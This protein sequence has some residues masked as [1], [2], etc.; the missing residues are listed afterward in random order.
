VAAW[1]SISASSIRRC[2]PRSEYRSSN[3][4]QLD[5]WFA[6][7]CAVSLPF[8]A[9]DDDDVG[10]VVIATDGSTGNIC[11]ITALLLLLLFRTLVERYADAVTVFLVAFD[12]DNDVDGF[13]DDDSCRTTSLPTKMKRWWLLI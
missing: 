11:G 12:D 1:N 4:C 8:V 5:F 2:C 6:L 3:F 9:D 7:F 10:I 13:D